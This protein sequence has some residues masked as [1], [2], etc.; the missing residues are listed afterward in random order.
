VKIKQEKAMETKKIVA[1]TINSM[2]KVY[3]DSNEFECEKEGT[4][5]C[6]E[7]FHF[8]LALRNISQDVLYGVYIKAE[9]KLGKYLELRVV[10][11]VPCEMAAF[12]A[13]DNYYERKVS[14]LYPDI[15][16]PWDEKGLILP[17]NG[18]W[19]SVWITIDG[20]GLNLSTGRYDI[21]LT[22]LGTTGEILGRCVY[23]L[24]ICPGKLVKNDY[25]ITHWMHYDGIAARNK[26]KLFSKKFYKVFDSYLKL[27]VQSGNTML[28]TPLFTPPLDTK[29][30]EERRT[31]QL[32]GVHNKNGKYVFD[33]SELE[34]FIEF[35]REHGIKY[36]EFSH[37][38]TQWGGEFC[39]KIM[40]ETEVGEQRIFGWEKRADSETYKAFL[41]V[42][43]PALMKFVRSKGLEEYCFVHLTDE[44]GARHI[45]QYLRCKNMVKKY[46]GNMRIMDALSDYEFYEKKGVEVPAVV[47][48]EAEN[49]LSHGVKDMLIYYCSYPSDRFYSNRFLGMPSQRNRII[50]IQLYLAG[51]RGFLHWGFNFYNSGL[52]LFELNPY[53]E[54]D[55]GGFFPGGDSFVVYPSENGAIAS[56]RLEVFYDGIQ[57]CLALRALEKKKGRDFVV[58]LIQTEGVYGMN[59]YPRSAK[60]H[61]MF[62]DKVNRLL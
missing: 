55:G 62:R 13:S 57:D 11:N 30:G 15:L 56:L 46:I 16:Q 48:P 25:I 6:N 49:F 28:L 41:E 2:E 33:F 10:R 51:V 36:F 31:A 42:F 18:N 35:A 38:F 14:G 44:P 8:Q 7:R 5:L 4:M 37:L 29:P 24:E 19:K 32:V 3:P 47:T 61:K 52:S 20:K 45:E 9:G 27:Y 17:A 54:P 21:P 1:L 53:M 12:S 59:V 22:I 26:V 50:G 60:W 23:V 43:L 40:A 39:P 34:K 58:K